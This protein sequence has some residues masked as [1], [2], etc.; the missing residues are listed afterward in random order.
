MVNS[1]DDHQLCDWLRASASALGDISVSD[2]TDASP[3]INTEMIQSRS[4][5][6]DDP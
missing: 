2:A 1:E 5:F 3:Q 4:S 6:I